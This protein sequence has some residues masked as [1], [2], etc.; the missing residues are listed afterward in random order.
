MIPTRFADRLEAGRLLAERLLHLKDSNPVI[1]ALPRGGVPIACEIARLLS[2]PVDVVLVRKIGAPQNEE[3]AIGAISDGEQPDIYI[4]QDLVAQL[5]VSPDY[6][7]ETEQAALREI[8]RRRRLY[9]GAHPPIPIAGHT[10]IVVDDGIATGATMLAA[11]QA[12]RRRN[13]ARLVLAAPVASAEAARRL[14]REVDESVILSVPEPFHAVGQ[15]YR[16]FPQ[17]TD[18]EVVQQLDAARRKH[19][20]GAGGDAA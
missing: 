3:Y 20:S 11:L 8:E 17:L 14:A 1:L 10:A 13:P 19:G 2:A 15:F 9:L 6:L 5:R 12:T 4:D 16:S 18:Q 7:R